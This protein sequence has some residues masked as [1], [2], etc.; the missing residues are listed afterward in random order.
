MVLLVVSQTVNKYERKLIETARKLPLIKSCPERRILVL[1][2]KC[3]NLAL[4]QRQER[5]ED[6]IRKLGVREDQVIECSA[7][8]YDPSL[9]PG[10]LRKRQKKVRY[11][12]W[13]SLS[14]HVLHS[15]L[16]SGRGMQ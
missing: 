13:L 14:W 12:S 5:R 15:W 3:D 8:A 16:T 2:T 9:T 4:A 11:L 7:A 10:E 6:I 1:M